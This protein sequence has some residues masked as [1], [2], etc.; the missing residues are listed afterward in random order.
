MPFPRALAQSEIQ[1]SDS[2][3]YDNFTFHDKKIYLF[4]FQMVISFL[5]LIFI[6]SE[7]EF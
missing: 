4:F 6:F 7:M 5:F 1:T 2:I 3:S